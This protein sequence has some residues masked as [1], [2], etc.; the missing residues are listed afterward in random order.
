MNANGNAKGKLEISAS[1][2][3]MLMLAVAC[4]LIVANLYY[5]QPLVESISS[6]IGLSSGAAGLSLR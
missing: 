3:I 2:W 1:P 5:T 4:G 6:S